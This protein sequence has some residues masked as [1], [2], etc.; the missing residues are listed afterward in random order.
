[1]KRSDPWNDNL[2]VL[3]LQEGVSWERIQARYRQLVLTYHP[4]LNSSQATAERFREIAAAYESLGVL[5]MRQRVRSADELIRM[6][7]DPKVRQLPA[8]E[9]GIRMRYSSSANV[10]AAAACL[11][12]SLSGKTNRRLLVQALRDSDETVRRVA[13]EAL[14]KV[15]HVGD[16]LSAPLFLERALLSVFLHAVLRIWA[17]MLRNCFSGFW[18][19]PLQTAVN[20]S[21]LR[22]GDE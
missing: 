14:G 21:Q 10:R 5:R 8:E 18:P 17:R 15:G 3:G 6:Y 19:V 2:R 22:E 20:R 7:D 16:L 12:G 4:D 1:M 9:L 13:L 11:L